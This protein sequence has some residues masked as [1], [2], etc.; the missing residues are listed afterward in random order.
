MLDQVDKND[1]EKE[2]LEGPRGVG[3]FIRKLVKYCPQLCY[4]NI[5]ALLQLCERVNYHYR[6]A[7]LKVMINL[8]FFLLDESA[9]YQDLIDEL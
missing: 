2:E 1:S 8:C 4:S 9:K 6:Q 5:R 3:A 7:I